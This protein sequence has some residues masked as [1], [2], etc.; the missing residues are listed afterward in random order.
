MIRYRAVVSVALG[1]SVLTGHEKVSAALLT[2][3]DPSLSAPP[4]GALD[5]EP[6]LRRP[7]ITNKERLPSGNP[8]WGVPLSSLMVTRERPIFSPSRRPPSPPAVLPVVQVRP[9][10]PR[11]REPERPQLSLVGTV[12]GDAEGIA[13]FIDQTTG[14]IIRLK[15]GEGHIGWTLSSVQGRMVTLQKN[16]QTETLALPNPTE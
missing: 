1:L 9:P 2:A 4:P 12:A 6:G 8:L 5:I 13:I 16:Q 7:E 15:T 11:P 3:P 14:N 10:P